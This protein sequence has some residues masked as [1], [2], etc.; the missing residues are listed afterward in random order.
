MIVVDFPYRV[1]FGYLMR[2]KLMAIFFVLRWV[3]N[4][5]KVGNATN[6]HQ[7]RLDLIYL[8][9]LIVTFLHLYFGLF[10]FFYH[11]IALYPIL[12]QKLFI[13]KIFN[14]PNFIILIP[15]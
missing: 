5:C 4:I 8:L 14:H 10:I 7:L 3:Q 1:L 2:I 15:L 6:E 13:V 11:F 12:H 9:N